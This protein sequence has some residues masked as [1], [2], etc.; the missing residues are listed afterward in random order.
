MT[1]V[2]YSTVNEKPL[3]DMT[4]GNSRACLNSQ[5]SGLRGPRSIK[6]KQEHGK[7]ANINTYEGSTESDHQNQNWAAG[8]A[9]LNDRVRVRSTLGTASGKLHKVRHSTHK[10]VAIKRL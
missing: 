3:L 1:C 10:L 2:P 4:I 8:G 7:F 5:V 9:W 6:I